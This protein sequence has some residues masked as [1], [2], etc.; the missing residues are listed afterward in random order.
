MHEQPENTPSLS[1]DRRRSFWRLLG[2]RYAAR[3]NRHRPLPWFGYA[4]SVVNIVAIAFFVLD[5][6]LGR[7]ARDLPARLVTIAGD[8]TNVGQILRIFGTIIAISVI[9]LLLVRRMADLRRPY[10]IAYLIW[11]TAY[12]ALSVLSASAVVHIVK[13]VIGR[14]RPLVYD[15]YGIFGFRPFDGHF[16]FQSFPSAH[17]TQV[18]AFFVALALLFPRFR[19][20]LVAAALWI[21]A[22]RVILGVHYP[23]D[24]AAG[25]ALGAWFAFATAIMFSRFGLLFALSPGGLP[26]PRVRRLL[27][28]RPLADG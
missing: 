13:T 24:V 8:I 10:R 17:S 9:G 1:A 25:L 21:G 5:E 6:P 14:A 11:I 16:L 27:R 2:A 7:T 19:L 26:V 20:V 28:R 22:T 4:L 15:Q 23:S 12:L 18:G 3:R